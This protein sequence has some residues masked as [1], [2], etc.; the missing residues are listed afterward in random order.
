MN[1]VS[2]LETLFARL[3]PAAAIILVI[4]G[5]G[6]CNNH[7][8]GGGKP[9]TSFNADTVA[10]HV[11]SIGDARLLTNTFKA[12]LEKFRKTCPDFPDSTKFGFAEEFPA[13]VFTAL[14]EEHNDKQGRAKGI[15]VYFGRVP[16]GEIKLIMVPVDS[17]GNDMI[18]TIIKMNPPA[19][20]AHI[21][22][23]TA[24]DPGQA[25][26]KGQRCPTACDDGAS[27]L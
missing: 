21:E 12:S 16:D 3:L 11:I 15:R 14:L 23:K 27:G 13:D 17:L 10:N 8:D 6:G 20:S 5:L 25:V 19:G 1:K 18:G 26:D 4:A 9:P 7:D 24:T 2:R 22:A